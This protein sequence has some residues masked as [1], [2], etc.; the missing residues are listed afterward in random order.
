MTQIVIDDISLVV[1]LKLDRG[2]TPTYQALDPRGL[3]V[4]GFEDTPELREHLADY[5]NGRIR[6]EPRSFL[7]RYRFTK[8]QAD[9][10][11]QGQRPQQ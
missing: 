1:T 10:A 2:I 7:A 6:V 4:W 3:S 8:S 9:A 11:A 5:K